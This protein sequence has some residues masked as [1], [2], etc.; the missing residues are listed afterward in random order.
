MASNILSIGQ[1]ALAAA[2]VGI[3]VTG[4]NIANAST[5]GYSRQQIVQSAAQAQDFG[6]GYLG[7]G[8]LVSSVTRV[9]NEL[10]TKQLNNAQ[11]SS[12]ATNAYAAHMTQI[13]NMLSD[14]AAGLSPSIQNFFASV[15]ALSSNPGDV[16][17]RQAMLS[18]AEGLATRFQSLDNRLNEMRGSVNSELATSATQ[19]TS[20]AAKIAQLNDVIS[21]AIGANSNNPPNDLLDQ[22]DQ[23]ISELSKLVKTDVYSQNDG[24]YNLSIGN[25]IP[26]VVGSKSYGL[27]TVNSPEDTGRLEIAYVT[28][29]I[30]P[31]GE[32]SL[33]GGKIGGLLQFRSGALDTIQN[34]LGQISTVIAQTFND[35]HQAG[36]DANGV[37]GGKFFNVPTPDVFGGTSNSVGAT[38]NATISNVAALTSS[39]Y[40]VNYDGTNYNITRV[41]DNTIQTFTSLPQTLDGVTF[42]GTMAA[43]DSF[44]VEP[45]RNGASKLSVAITNTSKIAAADATGGTGNNRNALLLA[46]LQSKGTLNNGTTSYENAFGQLVSFVGVKTNE[47]KVNAAAEDTLVTQTTAAQQSESGVNLDEEATNLIRYQQAYQAAGKVMQIASNLFD[48]LLALGH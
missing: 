47:L 33:P 25:G 31:L 1:S 17:S 19:V 35:Q 29:I 42:N 9:Y 34:Q 27:T 26:L 32:S 6:F 45:T 46:A 43:G 2:Q 4:H 39:D 5:P 28:N 11:S 15:Q 22:R 8:T 37:A 36:F 3:S 38:L 24:S 23:L 12:Q 18:T 44:L 10:L 13:D 7:Q 20:Y 21:K 16:A 48:T 40:R 14:P 41:S 30:K